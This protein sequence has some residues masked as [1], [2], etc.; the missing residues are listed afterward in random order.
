MTKD[1]TE[2]KCSLCKKTLSISE[3]G[4]F[5]EKRMGSHKYGKRR[6]NPNGGVRYYNARCKKCARETTR[7]WN[8][9]NKE[10]MFLKSREWREGLKREV[11]K[12]YGDICNCC[13]ESDH[14]FLTLDHINND[15]YKERRRVE[16]G[17]VRGRKIAGQMYKHIIESGFPDDLQLLCYNCNCGKQRNFGVCPHVEIIEP[18]YGSRVG[19]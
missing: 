7:N 10:Y 12:H 5:L 3:F 19:N 6:P 1:V 11:Y 13:G 18:K 8:R 15:G 16:P 2:K 14:M 4:T 9:A 17:G